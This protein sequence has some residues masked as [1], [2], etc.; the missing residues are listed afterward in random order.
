[1]FQVGSESKYKEVTVHQSIVINI[2]IT[3]HMLLWGPRVHAMK[4]KMTMGLKIVGSAAK[5]FEVEKDKN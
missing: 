5:K 1:M 2:L 4:N 3:I